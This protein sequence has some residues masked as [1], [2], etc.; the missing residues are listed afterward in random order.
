ML[1]VEGVPVPK[2][3]VEV[4]GTDGAC[5]TELCDPK[6][7]DVVWVIEEEPLDP[8]GTLLNGLDGRFKAVGV[9]NRLPDVGLF[10]LVERLGFDE[11][12]KPPKPLYSAGGRTEVAAVPK[13][14][15]EVEVLILLGS[16]WLWLWLWLTELVPGGF[17]LE[18]EVTGPYRETNMFGCV[19][20]VEEDGTWDVEGCDAD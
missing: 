7:V 10:T 20:E 5:D 1:V 14:P 15:L 11:D 4:T 2:N 19:T 6:R 17:V 16:V 18:A 3:E 13:R 12:D 9:P 8:L